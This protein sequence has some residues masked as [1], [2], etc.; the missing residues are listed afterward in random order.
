M[1]IEKRAEQY[2]IASALPKM[3]RFASMKVFGNNTLNFHLMVYLYKRN[4]KVREFP[5]FPMVN[6]ISRFQNDFEFENNLY[7][8]PISILENEVFET[9][10]PLFVE[11]GT[12]IRVAIVANAGH[13]LEDFED[14]EINFVLN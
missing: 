13:E 5:L 4:I 3:V 2:E 9:Q 6:P 8:P 10:N 7:F 11:P 1:R 12:K 14:C